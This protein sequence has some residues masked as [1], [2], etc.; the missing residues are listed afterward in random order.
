MGIVS[1][2]SSYLNPSLKVVDYVETILT[3]AQTF[4]LVYLVWKF[5]NWT[6]D[7]IKRHALGFVAAAAV[8]FNLPK[9]LTFIFGCSADTDADAAVALNPNVVVSYDFNLTH[10]VKTTLFT[11][12]TTD[13]YLR[14]DTH[15]GSVTFSNVTIETIRTETPTPGVI[16]PMNFL[17]FN[18][19]SSSNILLF[20]SAIFMICG[21]YGRYIKS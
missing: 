3:T 17:C 10:I 1:V 5:E 4:V 20:V 6:N 8:C 2:A 18:F 19:C 13:L 12:N 7:K 15:D 11:S 14:N 16:C 9:L 21:R